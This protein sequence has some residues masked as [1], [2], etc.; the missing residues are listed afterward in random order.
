MNPDKNTACYLVCAVIFILLKAGFTFAGNGDLAFLLK[1]TAKIVG[2]LTGM[3]SVYI[4]AAGYFF[5]GLNIVIDKSCSGFNFWILCFLVF[6]YLAVRRFSK[7]LQ[8]TLSIAASLICAYLLTI[9]ANASRIFTSVIVQNQ[10]KDFFQNQQRL[11]HEAV[12]II[13]YLSLLI[14][15]CC[16][17]EKKL[18]HRKSDAKPA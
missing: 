8:K 16:L 14:F 9:F 6:S 1:P 5:S 2:L 12:G 13:V 4:P 15:A 7:P 10:T 11:I 17:I 18:K 3:H